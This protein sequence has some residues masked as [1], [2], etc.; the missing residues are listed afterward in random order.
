[1]TTRRILL[2]AVLVLG[3]FSMASLAI[4]GGGGY[5]LDWFTA[6]GGGGNTAGGSYTLS[7]T[8]GQPD[9]GALSGGSYTLNGGFW[10]TTNML[11]YIPVVRK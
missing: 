9:A 4:A 6:D 11:V 10:H 2:I 7:S 8:I 3:L 5:T 1:M